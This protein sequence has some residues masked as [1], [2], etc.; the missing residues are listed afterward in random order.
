MER[1]A[2]VFGSHEEA[3]QATR[4]YY[5]NLTPA[6]RLNILLE[7]IARAHPTDHDS[8]Q[9]LARVYRITQLTQR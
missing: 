4:A 9:G 6:E 8:Q 3:D 2:K 7:I 1:V 5:R